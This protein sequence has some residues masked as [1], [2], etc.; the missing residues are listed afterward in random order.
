M[1]FIIKI[2]LFMKACF[3]KFIKK[4]SKFTKYII[5]N[6]YRRPSST[7]DELA[8]IT[9]TDEFTIVTQNMQE[10]HIKA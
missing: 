5:G 7:L 10:Q 1:T 3:L 8:Q 2:R 6:I 4:S 9:C